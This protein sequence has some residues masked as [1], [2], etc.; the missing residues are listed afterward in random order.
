MACVVNARVRAH[1]AGGSY[2]VNSGP[3][4]TTRGLTI[5]RGD[6]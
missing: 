4:G 2:D 1:A 3:E 5:P 6:N